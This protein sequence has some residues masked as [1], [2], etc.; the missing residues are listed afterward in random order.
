M[1]RRLFLSPTP[2]ASSTS[3]LLPSRGSVLQQQCSLV[4]FHSG[5][6]ASSS[7]SS[8]SPPGGDGGGGAS[9]GSGQGAPGPGGSPNGGRG[10]GVYGAKDE[11]PNRQH[12][13]PIGTAPFQAPVGRGDRP[14]RMGEGEREAASFVDEQGRPAMPGTRAGSSKADE[15]DDPQPDMGPSA[16]ASSSSSASAAP[17]SGDKTSGAGGQK[18]VV[19][20]LAA[21]QQQR[22]KEM[23]GGVTPKARKAD[24]DKETSYKR[25]RDT[26]AE[27]S[28][29]LKHSFA[30][31]ADART[32]T[33]WEELYYNYLRYWVTREQLIGKDRYGNK[34]C[35]RWFFIR[36]RQEERRMYR[37]DADKQHQPY[38][39]LPTDSKLWEAWMRRWRYDPPTAEEDEYHRK[40]KRD[41]MGVHVVADEEAEDTTMRA[42]A[43]TKHASYQMRELDNNEEYGK[44]MVM[45][46]DQRSKEANP[47][48]ELDASWSA[49]VVRGDLFYNEEETETL[50]NTVAT[51]FRDREWQELELKRQVRLKK[52]KNPV[53][54]PQYKT[55]ADD[56][57]E[58][59]DGEPMDHQWDRTDSGVPF[60]NGV[61]DLTTPELEKLKAECDALEEERIA[62]R[63]ELGLT[64]TGDFRENRAP[65]DKGYDPFQ[66]PPT[67]T[68]WKPKCWSESWGAGGGQVY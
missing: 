39:A 53:R 54:R 45:N 43:H 6:Y 60:G 19:Y 30:G 17:K 44:S 31:S 67:S 11:Y 28:V 24:P 29:S 41:F 55:G 61:S 46:T 57:V 10:S 15:D 26:F 52:Q 23:F 22:N 7:S 18:P 14:R 56:T 3:S 51:M 27:D 49:A 33:W 35:V 2:S 38:G 4:L 21:Q 32:I 48:K 59:V 65:V 36:E 40:R 66:P 50:R 20:G 12:A 13:I 68:R 5:R 47:A 64:D 37:I 9:S 1:R 62:L 63:R 8:G 34:F 42:L 16:T 25:S 58:V